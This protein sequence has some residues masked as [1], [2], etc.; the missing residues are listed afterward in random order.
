MS[1]RIEK[2]EYLE[3]NICKNNLHFFSL[4]SKSIECAV[5][6]LARSQMCDGVRI[7]KENDTCQM[8]QFSENV[9]CYKQ[10]HQ[11][12]NKRNLLIGDHNVGEIKKSKCIAFVHVVS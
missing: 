6:C 11:N 4:E 8:V 10:F 3:I 5:K 1:L 2:A 7:G 12:N 9:V